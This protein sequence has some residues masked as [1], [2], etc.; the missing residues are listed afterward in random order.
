MQALANLLMHQVRH[1][2][3]KYGAMQKILALCS[4]LCDYFCVH[5]PGSSS[6]PIADIFLHSPPMV[7]SSRGLPR[8]RFFSVDGAETGALRDANGC[9]HGLTDPPSTY[10]YLR[11]CKI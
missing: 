8:P 5:G 11:L 9:C 10:Y 1:R 7:E 6:F 2:Q 3:T 4:A